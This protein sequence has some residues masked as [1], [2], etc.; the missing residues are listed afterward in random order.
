MIPWVGDS[1]FVIHVSKSG[2]DANGG[3]AQQYP[4]SLANDAKLTISSAVSACPD[5]GIIIV[6]PG[7]YAETVD[8]KTA[9]KVGKKLF[10]GIG[11]FAKEE[12]KEH[13]ERGARRG[14]KERRTL[15]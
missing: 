8:I 15:F 14:K 5:G 11:K 13:R 2:D 9:A 6:W 1:S 3:V 7:D 12:A 10:G 4:V